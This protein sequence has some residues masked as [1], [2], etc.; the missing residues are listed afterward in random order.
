MIVKFAKI[1]F[2]AAAIFGIL[3]LTLIA[4]AF[5]YLKNLTMFSGSDTDS[6]AIPAG[7]HKLIFYDQNTFLKGVDYAN[8]N[9]TDF[10]A[11]ARGGII[12]HHLFP[13]FILSDFFPRL[14]KENPKRVI[15]IGPN[16]REE[17]KY[18]ILT[19]QFAWNTPYGA[20]LPDMDVI[21]KF[22]DKGLV[23]VNETVLENEHSVAGIMPYVK[24]YLP[25]AK[26]VPLILRS[27]MDDSE[28]A[29]LSEDLAD[30]A[31][32][33]TFIIASTD[34]SHYLDA[35]TA[36]ANDKI[37]LN[38]IENFD[39]DKL[40]RF[41]NGYVDSPASV[42]VLLKTLQIFGSTKFNLFF[43]TNSGLIENAPYS[44]TTS[45]FS[46]MFN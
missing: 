7:K 26:V 18:K 45:Y 12:P 1:K 36:A 3:M 39:Y 10:P 37:T 31:D 38:V 2:I 22:K 24:Y 15:I 11:G 41:S 30:I 33:N 25:D 28:I 46:G 34:F 19:S 42:A 8:Q 23:H 16:H 32:K 6:A 17:G 9:K 29:K 13:S 21:N 40:Y 35:Q 43:N 27:T 4:A 5:F 44:Q 20:V 14:A